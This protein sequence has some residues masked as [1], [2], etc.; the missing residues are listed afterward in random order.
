MPHVGDLEEEKQPFLEDMNGVNNDLNNLSGNSNSN[1]HNHGF[2]HNNLSHLSIAI[3]HHD[4]D[5]D[6]ASNG[7]NF[8]SSSSSSSKSEQNAREARAIYVMKILTALFYAVASFLITVVNKIV[9]T[10]YK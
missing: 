2:L 1:S 4:K 10:S 7:N 3:S 6:T 5:C 8:P 9:L